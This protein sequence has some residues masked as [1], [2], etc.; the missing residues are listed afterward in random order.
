MDAWKPKLELSEY[1]TF[2]ILR[3]GKVQYSGIKNSGIQ[4]VKSKMI[5]LSHVTGHAIWILVK[6]SK[7]GLNTKHSVVESWFF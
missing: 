7:Q 2:P 6:Y 4:M 5:G 3:I 1:W